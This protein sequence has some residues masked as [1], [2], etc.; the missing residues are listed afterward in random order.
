MMMVCSVGVDLAP[1]QSFEEP[2]EREMWERGEAHGRRG[3]ESFPKELPSIYC[4]V[5]SSSQG[6]LYIR[7]W[8]RLTPPPSLP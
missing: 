7:G 8:G 3:E 1:M 6:P 4:V 5:L 2:H